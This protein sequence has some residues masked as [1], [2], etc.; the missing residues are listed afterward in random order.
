MPP[1]PA[2]HNPPTR[3]R[4]YVLLGALVALGALA[5]WLATDFAG[6]VLL[7]VAAAGWALVRNVGNV[8]AHLP[9]FRSSDSH[10]VLLGWGARGWW[11][12][13]P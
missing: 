7:A 2:T 11:G 5:W 13:Q 4:E 3:G 12:W 10:Q 9:L 8:R 6:V 1:A